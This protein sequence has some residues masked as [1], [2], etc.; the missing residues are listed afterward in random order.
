M[1]PSSTA[2]PSR[3]AARRVSTARTGSGPA[4]AVARPRWASAARRSPACRDSAIS[5]HTARATALNGVADGTSISG[6]P[7]R[8]QAA[9]RPRGTA[10]CTGATP[11]PS[12]APPAATIRPTYASR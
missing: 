9:T 4:A 5:R 3:R 12:A 2:Y 8:S 10:S 7:Q 11:K 6:S 1:G